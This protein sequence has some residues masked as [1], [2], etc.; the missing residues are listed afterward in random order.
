MAKGNGRSDPE[1]QEFEK[2]LLTLLPFLNAFAR[3]LTGSREAGE[4]LAQDALIKAIL[5]RNQFAVGS[6][7][8]AWLFTIARNSWYSDRRRAW[9]WTELN[10]AISN[11]LVTKP[12]VEAEDEFRRMLLCLACLPQEQADAVIAVGYL[13]MPY[14]EAGQCLGC[15]VG[16]V[17][18]RVARG[19]EALRRLV[20]SV[21]TIK[22]ID[23]EWFR[24]A[25]QSVP[26]NH[27]LYPIAK[28]YEDLY[29]ELNGTSLGVNKTKN[30]SHTP[31]TTETKAGSLEE[32]W[33][34]LVA[35]GAL[36]EGAESLEELMR[37]DFEDL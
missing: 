17:K 12:E 36:D 10:D 16:T 1:R 7:L 6:N 15:A 35:S 32:D 31:A 3:S 34:G 20:D 21:D 37:T 27:R 22:H 33:K 14:K 8:K 13:G 23:M 29:A 11:S 24:T 18:S 30:G 26:K 19:R 25:V 4:D 9:R 28:A 5:A 2:Q